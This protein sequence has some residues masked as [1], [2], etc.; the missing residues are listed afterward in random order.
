MKCAKRVTRSS[1]VPSTEGGI[2]FRLP[3]M[4]ELQPS[5]CYAKLC[6]ARPDSLRCSSWV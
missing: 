6:D 2:Q 5:S 1:V 4:L 3:S